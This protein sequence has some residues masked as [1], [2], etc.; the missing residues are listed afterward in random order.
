MI[1]KNIS[2]FFLKIKNY[3]LIHP[4]PTFY[5]NGIVFLKLICDENYQGFGEVSP[6]V[7]SPKNIIK[8]CENNII[9][10]TKI[11]TKK[12]SNILGKAINVDKRNSQ[13]EA[14]KN[15]LLKFNINLK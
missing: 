10:E 6:Y 8:N 1:I 9:Y 13:L 15:A 4:R 14:A 5:K 11:T 7:G 3:N 2:I 12:N